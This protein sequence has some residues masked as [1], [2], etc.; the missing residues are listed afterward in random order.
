[1][2]GVDAFAVSVDGPVSPAN[3][4]AFTLLNE[5]RHRHRQHVSSA[6]PTTIDLSYFPF[7]PSGLDQISVTRHDDEEARSG[8]VDSVTAVVPG[9][10][11]V[12]RRNL[13]ER[14]LSS[15]V[16]SVRLPQVPMSPEAIPVA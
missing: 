8:K 10:R 14:P 9:M 1:M 12:L 3:D 13:H 2:S 16:A 11:K 7:S 5:I 6:E 15:I 4:K